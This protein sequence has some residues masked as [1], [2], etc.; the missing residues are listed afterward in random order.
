MF[1][2]VQMKGQSA[3]K[4]PH[5]KIKCPGCTCGQDC[6]PIWRRRFS[7]FVSLLSAGRE[8]VNSATQEVGT[9]PEAAPCVPLDP[10]TRWRRVCLCCCL[11][12]FVCVRVGFLATPHLISRHIPNWSKPDGHPPG[13]RI[14]SKI[15]PVE[16]YFFFG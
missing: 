13:A 6:G 14:C 4:R 10:G 9:T 15:L 12:M 5:L 1:I 2:C 7:I 3:K 16:R 11:C 8:N